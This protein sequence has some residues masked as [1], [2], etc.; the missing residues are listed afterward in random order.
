MADETHGCRMSRGSFLKKLYK[1]RPEQDNAP[2]MTSP[3]RLNWT[4][5]LFVAFAHLVALGAVFYISFIHFSW[6]T[7]GLGVVYTVCCGLSITGGY[8]RLFAHGT[9]KAS[10]IVR[11]FYLLFG[12]ASVQNSAL[13]WAADHRTHHAHTNRE[14]DPYDSRRGFWWSHLGWVLH[15]NPHRGFDGVD[16]LKRS[17]L[18]VFQHRYYVPLA[19][20]MG[21]VVPLALGFLWGDPIGAV[22]VVGFLRLVFQWHGTFSI[23]SLAHMFGSRRYCAKSSARDSAWLA[24][25][26][27]GEGYHNF[28]HRFPLDYRNGVRWFHFDPTKWWVWTLSWL[29]QTWDLRRASQERIERAR[30]VAAAQAAGS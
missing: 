15:K 5:V 3:Q 22:L 19:F 25:I 24:F 26:T 18:M 11:A 2:P 4:N 29:G 7:L 9:Y 17:R 12:A 6:W 13:N 16:D 30:E 28:H 14:R 27:L 23:N 1:H 21:G 20:L 8:H 10:S